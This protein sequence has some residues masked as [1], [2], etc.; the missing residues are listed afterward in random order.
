MPHEPNSWL[1]AEA[2]RD[3]FISRNAA[4]LEAAYGKLRGA[5]Q[6][7]LPEV[8]DWR[9]AEYAFNRL[10]VGPVALE[11]PPFASVYLDNEPLVMGPTTMA[12]R[13]VYALLGLES[14]WKNTLPDDHVSLELDAALALSRAAGKVDLPDLDR[15]RRFFVAEHM[16]AWLPEFHNRVTNSTSAHPAITAAA[17]MVR[18][19]AARESVLIKDGNQTTT[20]SRRMA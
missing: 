3:F 17:R 15:V 4:E 1:Q 13:Q 7:P 20:P 12:V 10:F 18:D 9:E 14:P 8:R 6:E 11:A 2:L 5:P 16:N 19:W